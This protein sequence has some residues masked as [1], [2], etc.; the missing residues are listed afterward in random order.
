MSYGDFGENLRICVFGASHAE[1]VGVR[2]EGFPAD[3][4]VDEAAL[5]A[6]LARRSPGRNAWSSAR[7]EPDL[8]VFS[9]GLKDGRTTGGPIVAVIPNKDVRSGDYETFRRIPRPGHADYT[10]Y[11]RYGK[12][13]DM[14]GG[15]PFSGRMT[16]PL[17]LAGGIALQYLKQRGIEVR[18][19]VKSIGSITDKSGFDAPV[20]TKDF[21]VSDEDKAAEMKALIAA[22]KEA[23]DSV[24]GT[25]E[26]V[27]E[28]LPAGLGGP[29][30]EGM[31][32]CISSIVFA[33]PAVKGIEFGA[34]FSAAE[35]KGSENNDAFTLEE[36]TVKT[37]TN[38][39][40]GILGG[41][42]DG[43]PLVFRAAFKPTPSIALPQ[44]SVDLETMTETELRIS[45][46]HDPCIVPRAVPVI[47]A[48]AAL[49]VLDALSEEKEEAVDRTALRRKIDDVD[50]QLTALFIERM[51]ISE[52]I[53][54]WK[55]EN[56][57]PIL[58]RQREEEKLKA[59]QAACPEELREDVR[60][61]YETL[62]TL[63]RN[64]QER[65]R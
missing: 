57:I 30:F 56:N 49:A 3:F 7:K 12:D 19:R 51:R 9:E 34:G 26:C 39:A 40:G 18:A 29:L 4:A 31:E 64:C 15:G 65:E 16:A 38:H 36:G 1:A 10:A 54:R 58:D 60:T 55:K 11:V 28:G 33:I 63:S 46:R 47:E 8:P 62:F 20:D 22:C 27:V 13:F 44:K 17:T 45:G 48:A 37:A 59:I 6:F 21:P 52:K 23:G 24:G 5:G 25:V 35:M 50:R 43:M 61:L 32:G 53:G 41:I 2:M 42:T 14:R